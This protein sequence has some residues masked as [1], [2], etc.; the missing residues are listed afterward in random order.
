[1]G[2]KGRKK[3]NYHYPR[4]RV[5]AIV[6]FN[7][8]GEQELTTSKGKKKR[9]KKKKKR[10]VTGVDQA[11]M[12][13]AALG[14]RRLDEHENRHGGRIG[15]GRRRKKG[16]GKKRINSFIVS[17]ILV[18]LGDKCRLVTPIRCSNRK[19]ARKGKGRR[20][21]GEKKRKE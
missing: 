10:T 16:G 1:M 6:R 8:V 15:G 18:V 13:G 2:K 7:F 5:C 11:L 12:P 19:W 3:K 14:G 9:K 21:E 17:P 20:K 4:R